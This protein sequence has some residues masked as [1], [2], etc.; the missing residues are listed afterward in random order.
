MIV[1]DFEGYCQTC[2]DLEPV[3]E[4]LYAESGIIQQVITC[5]NIQRCRNIVRYVRE[6]EKK[7][8]N[9]NAEN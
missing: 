4:R 1:T 3:V 2:S 6:Y 9:N 5:E 7:G 8:E